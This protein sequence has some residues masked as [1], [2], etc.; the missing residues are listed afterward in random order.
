MSQNNEDKGTVPT[1]T[2][3][4]E[5]VHLLEGAERGPTGRTLHL[6]LGAEQHPITQLCQ[7]WVSRTGTDI[8]VVSVHCEREAADATIAEIKQVAALGDLF[9]EA[10]VVGMVARL[11]EAGDGESEPFSRETMRTICRIIEAAV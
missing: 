4:A 10:G 9:D 2:S 5:D 1:T 11:R 8:Q 3:Q 7:V 6:A